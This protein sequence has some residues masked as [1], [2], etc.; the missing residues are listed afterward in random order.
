MA[1]PVTLTVVASAI[2]SLVFK[3]YLESTA[4]QVAEKLNPVVLSKINALRQKIWQK[5]RGI[6]EVEELN[7]TVEAGGTV[8]EQQVKLLTPHLEAAMKDD[9]AFDREIRNLAQ[10]IQQEININ[11]GSGSEVWNVIG[12]AEKNEFIDNKAPV[13]KDNTGT[14]NINYGQPPA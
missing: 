4:E 9:P 5:L 2:L 6:R 3:P 10:Q 7:K 13:I 11:Q 1:D 12:H 8:T 14:I